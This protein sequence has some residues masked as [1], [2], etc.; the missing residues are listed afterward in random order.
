LGFDLIGRLVSEPASPLARRADIDWIRV[1]AFGILILY[2]VGLVYAPWDW[3]VHSP[4]TFEW[5][6]Y[7]IGRAHV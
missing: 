3:H 5:L 7:E 4:H 2:H 1:A 6:R